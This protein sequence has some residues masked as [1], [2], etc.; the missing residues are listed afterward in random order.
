VGNSREVLRVSKPNEI[1]CIYL[2]MV[3]S[4]GSL[5]L[6]HLRRILEDMFGE[7]P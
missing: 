1:F 6:P 2:P 3:E 4:L 7:I 5:G